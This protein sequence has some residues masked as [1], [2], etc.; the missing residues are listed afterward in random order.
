MKI[1]LVSIIRLI[2][3]M[4]I[5]LVSIMRHIYVLGKKYEDSI[6]KR[7]DNLLSPGVDTCC[8]GR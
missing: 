8:R 4:K 6:G 7:L 3:V 2:N 5:L 1:L